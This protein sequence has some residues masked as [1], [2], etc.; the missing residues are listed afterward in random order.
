MTGAEGVAGWKVAEER[1][2]IITWVLVRQADGWR[3]AA[4]HNTD[5][6]MPSQLAVGPCAQNGDTQ[7][8]LCP[9][10]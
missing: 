3:I 1:R 6:L 5:T 4:S 7:D 8:S 9:R 2:G 10:A